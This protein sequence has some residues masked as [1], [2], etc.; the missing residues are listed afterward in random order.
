MALVGTV[1]TKEILQLLAERDL[2]VHREKIAD[3][4]DMLGLDT[5][6][7][8]ANWCP[9]R[10]L[11]AEAEL[12]VLAIELKSWNLSNDAIRTLLTDGGESIGP[13]VQ[14]LGTSLKAFVEAAELVTADTERWKEARVGSRARTAYKASAA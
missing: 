3:T 1:G 4:S 9:R 8:E 5:R 2:R 12:I 10:W 7:V 14:R 6:E 13:L 11:P